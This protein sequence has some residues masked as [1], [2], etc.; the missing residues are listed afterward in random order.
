MRLP[1]PVGAVIPNGSVDTSG[2]TG[3]AS[4]AG[5]MLG[6]AVAYTGGTVLALLPDGMLAEISGGHRPSSDG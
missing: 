5:T 4:T 6:S 2:S 1:S 3:G